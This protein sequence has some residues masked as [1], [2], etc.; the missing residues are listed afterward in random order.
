MSIGDDSQKAIIFDPHESLDVELKQWIDPTSPE[1]RAIIAR[2]CMA[3]RNND[4]GRLIIGFCDDGS[5]DYSNVPENVRKTFHSDAIHQI[6][7]DFASEPFGIEVVFESRDEQEYPVIIVPNGVRTPVASRRDLLAPSNARSSAKKGDKLLIKENAIYVRT[8]LANHRPSSSEAKRG[9]WNR[10]VQICFDNREA[11][12]GSFVRRHL[13]T[14]DPSSVSKLAESLA[15]ELS[16]PT[17]EDRVLDELKSG[18]R[19]FSE[20]VLQAKLKDAESNGFK[21]V[22]IVVGGQ[23]PDHKLDNDFRMRL[24]LNAPNLSGWPPFVDL[25]HGGE[26]QMRPYIKANGWQALLAN[27]DSEDDII[28]PSLDFW[29]IEP[30]GVFFVLRAL[31]DDLHPNLELY[32]SLDFYLQIA[33]TTEVIIAGLSLANSLGCDATTSVV[34]FGF[35]WTRLENRRLLAWAGP[36]RGLRQ[37]GRSREDE[38]TSLLSIPL[39]TPANGVAPH[40][41]SVVRPLFLLFGGA[42]YHAKVIED[43]VESVRSRL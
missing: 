24:L 6:I 12:I 21:E 33:W 19:H 41:D 11:D 38:Y 35:R 1:G 29:R 31:E 32:D 30:R 8:L 16:M 37:T 28:R 22:A 15:D 27:L 2:S 14:L 43:A 26:L 4:G 7:A 3:L 17:V 42:E 23:V 10:L 40:V 39:D 36:H 25:S 34:H 5:P 18:E 9:D 13:S 20:A